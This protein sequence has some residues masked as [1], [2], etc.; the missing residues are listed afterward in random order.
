MAILDIEELRL[1][2]K[3]SSRSGRGNESGISELVA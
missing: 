2:R 3:N 1:G